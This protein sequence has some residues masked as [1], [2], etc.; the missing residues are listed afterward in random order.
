MAKYRRA[1]VPG[2]SW[3]F[4][5]NLAQR[6]VNKLLIIHLDELHMAFPMHQGKIPFSS[7]FRVFIAT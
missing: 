4:T 6:K 3:F 1:Y 7:K 2:A 5:V